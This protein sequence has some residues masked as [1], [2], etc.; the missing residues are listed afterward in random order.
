M[1][2]K[3]KSL[4]DGYF[5]EPITAVEINPFVEEINKPTENPDH[6]KNTEKST[7]STL[8]KASD[9]E[10]QNDDSFSPLGIIAKKIKS[11]ENKT[12][13]N[14][15]L[16]LEAIHEPK[17][18]Q[19]KS[20]SKQCLNGVENTLT[21]LERS[22]EQGLNGVQSES[23]Q[24][25]NGVENTLTVLERSPEQG[26]NGVQSESK[27]CLNGVENAD[28]NLL[29]GREK[30]LL[31]FVVFECQRIGSLETEPLTIERFK[32]TLNTS[33]D[34]VKTAIKRLSAKGFISRGFRKNGRSGWVQ[35]QVP[36]FVYERVLYSKTVSN[37][38]L[39][40]VQS[41][42]ER[43][44]ELG[45]KQGLNAPYSSSNNL[46]INTNT[47]ELPENLRRF[48]ISVVN[49]QNLVTSGKTT[50]EVIERSLAALSFDVG[51]GKTGNLANILF[52]VLGTGREY[53]SQKYSE[54]L[55]AELERELKRISEAEET[56][57]RVAEIQ[58]KEKFQKFTI[59]NPQF[60]ESVK[61]QHKG[62]IQN[63]EL[64]EK[65]ALEKFKALEINS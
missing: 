19:I 9:F 20:E 27:Q 28:P 62:Y 35:Y 49:L 21:V 54:T 65:I 14:L 26:L 61:T 48:G 1:S 33:T 51:N 18:S 5:D 17:L 31:E 16:Q 52:G 39:I 60:L 57:K 22:P 29:I 30:Q 23:K 24:C 50:Q 44:P 38:S 40:G 53:I 4:M 10:F 41:V 45:P 11:S 13:D 42:S 12:K 7:R 56:Q 8:A 63:P 43:R 32:E 55:Q 15:E 25:L 3:K 58:L 36:K 37:R 46:N 6:L 59:E 2:K 34:A 64:L 47:I